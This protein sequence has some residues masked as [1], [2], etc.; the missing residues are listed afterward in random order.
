MLF[1]FR[2]PPIHVYVHVIQEDQGS[3]ERIQQLTEKISTLTAKTEAAIKAD[4]L[5]EK[6]A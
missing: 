3:A 1:E 4:T 5:K 2:F 6:E